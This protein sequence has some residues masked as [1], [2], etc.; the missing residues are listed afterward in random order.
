MKSGTW[1]CV[2]KPYAYMQLRILVARMIRRFS[3]Q[4]AEG[5]SEEKVFR[6]AVDMFIMYL[7]K[8]ELILT[9]RGME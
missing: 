4:L 1:S 3:F 2:G 8:I 7:G 6:D 9:E 5:T